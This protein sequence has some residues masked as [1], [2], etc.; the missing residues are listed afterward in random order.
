MRRSR[1][2]KE[3]II[4]SIRYSRLA[5]QRL[6]FGACSFVS[7]FV[8]RRCPGTAVSWRLL[9]QSP[10][11]SKR[12]P[13]FPRPLMG[14]RRTGLFGRDGRFAAIARCRVANPPSKRDAQ[15]TD[16]SRVRQFLAYVFLSQAPTPPSGLLPSPI[17][18][19]F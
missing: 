18:A 7:H 8:L 15:E 13:W 12:P 1:F 4:A 11:F 5:K 17:S 9:L 2:K 14:L 16:R 3:Q 10:D 19:S 6:R